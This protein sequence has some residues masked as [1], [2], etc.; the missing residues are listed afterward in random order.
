M[1]SIDEIAAVVTGARGDSRLVVGI[2]GPPGSGKST[3]ADRLVERLGDE[4]VLLPM[5]GYHLPQAR[6]VE[7]GRRDRMGAADTFDVDALVATLTALRFSG[8][9]VL[10]PGFD[11]EIE[12]AIPDAIAIAPEKRV[13]VVE[14]NY[15][16]HDAQGWERVAPLIDLSFFVAVDHDI[17]LRRL[18]ERH[19]RFGKTPD[20]A[21]A[22]ATGPDEANARLIDGT[23]V[24]ADHE[25]RLG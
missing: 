23:A 2:V 13:L 17:R 15:L 7:L 21:A 14:G 22:W 20:A 1:R 3:T 8:G 11:R 4:A 6:L 9:L 16:L 5:D 25:I 24:R 18:I 19:V 10:A 12:E